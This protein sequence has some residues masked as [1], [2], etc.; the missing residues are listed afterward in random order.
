MASTVTT[1]KASFTLSSPTTPLNPPKQYSHHQTYSS[2]SNYIK[3]QTPPLS[4]CHS[5]LPTN[6]FNTP[7]S[8]RARNAAG[9]SYSPAPQCRIMSANPSVVAQSSRL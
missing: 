4:R 8:C 5:F 9:V 3:P 1:I 7:A 2:K 6:A